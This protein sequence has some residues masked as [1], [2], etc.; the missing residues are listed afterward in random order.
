MSVGEK[1]LS[2]LYRQLKKTRIAL[3]RAEYKGVAEEIANLQEKIETLEW[4]T[5]VAVKEVK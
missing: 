5:A 4:L 3:S 1:A 2:Y